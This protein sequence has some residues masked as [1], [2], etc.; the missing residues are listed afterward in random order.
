MKQRLIDANTVGEGMA[1]TWQKAIVKM[2]ADRAPTVD[3]ESLPLVIQ[4]RHRI[5][6][7]EYG[8][9]IAQNGEKNLK[10]QL[11][12]VE[13]ELADV[14]KRLKRAENERDNFKAF[15]DG[16]KDSHNCNDCGKAETCKYFPGIGETTRFNCPLW[17]KRESSNEPQNCFEVQKERHSNIEQDRSETSSRSKQLMVSGDV[18]FPLF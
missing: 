17:A 3:I 13:Q 2:E 11:Y 16:L 5:K 4:L 6:T 1:K 15:Y 9:D 18:I 8:L 7:L 12:L 14:I 10:H